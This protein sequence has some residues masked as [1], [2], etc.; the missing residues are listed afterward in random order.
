MKKI[1]LIL[2][3]AGV[4]FAQVPVRMVGRAGSQNASLQLDRSTYAVNVIDY[5]HHEVHSGNSFGV[6]TVD[7]DLDNG[8]TLVMVFTVPDTVKWMHMISIMRNTSSSLAEMLEGPTI[9]ANKGSEISIHNKNRNS[10]KVSIATSVAASPTIGKVSIGAA[11]TADGT[12]LE[13]E[14]I[15]TGKDKGAGETRALA[16]YILKQNKIYAFRLIGA[17]DNGNASIK[18]VWYEHTDKQ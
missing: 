10:T 16:E 5:A 4:C 13:P 15:G 6:S 18:L 1:A 3:I 9:G 2:L 7:A 14:Y 8:D 12:S 17:A 11:I